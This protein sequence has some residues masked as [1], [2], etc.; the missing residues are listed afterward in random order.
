MVLNASNMNDENGWD[1]KHTRDRV[2]Y[3]KILG[4]NNC[5]KQRRKNKDNFQKNLV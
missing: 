4:H 1:A 5:L 2:I 3:N